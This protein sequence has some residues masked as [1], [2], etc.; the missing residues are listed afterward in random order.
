MSS[1]LSR[2][3]LVSFGA[4]AL[5][6]LGLVACGSDSEGSSEAGG[7]DGGGEFAGTEITLASVPS[8]ESTSL[9]SGYENIIALLEQEL[10]VEVSY[11]DANDYAAVIEGQRAGQ[12]DMAAYGPFSY[13]IATDS[14][15]P[16]E[17][18]GTMADAPDEEPTYTSRLHVPADSDME[19]IEDIAGKQVCFVDAASTSGYLVPSYGLLDVD[20]D[21]E[22]DITPIMAGGHDASLLSLDSGNCDAAF[23]LDAQQSILEE[24]GQL[25]EGSMKV[26]WESDPIPSSPLTANT[27][28]LGEDLVTAINDTLAEKA[29]KPA[30]VEM[31][32]CE[33]EEDCTMPEDSEYGFIPTDDSSY[34]VIREICE[35]T[36]ADACQQVG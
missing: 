22:E 7:N 9:Q 15:V 26:I 30:L 24:T 34:E 35:V 10:G 6:P 5:L 33:S 27:E 29:N 4:I 2:R 8:E 3:A 19:S 17:P 36:Q 14:G 16:I 1:S 20:I 31:G 21:P 18:V 13:V 28:T 12:I 11:Q 32:I 25:E 23:A